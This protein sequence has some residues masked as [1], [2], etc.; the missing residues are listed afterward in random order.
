MISSPGHVQ[1]ESVIP[2]DHLSPSLVHR[3]PKPM[4]LAFFKG[5]RECKLHKNRCSFYFGLFIILNDNNHR[6][7]G[8]KL[9]L[10]LGDG[11]GQ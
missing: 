8:H 11:E 1:Y 9:G 4:N 6:F 10:T 5:T 7:S 3:L 2:G